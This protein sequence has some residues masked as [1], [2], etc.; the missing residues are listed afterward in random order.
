MSKRTTTPAPQYNPSAPRTSKREQ[1]RQERQRRNLTW[2]IIILGIAVVFLAAIGFAFYSGQR[3]GPLPGEQAVATENAAVFPDGQALT[4]NHYPP[5]SGARY[6]AAAPW[7][8]ATAPVDEGNYITNLYR[9]GVVFLYDCAQPCP[10]LEQQFRDLLA[11]ATPDSTYNTVKILVSP[12]P[13][14]K[15]LPAQ[16]VAL[17]WGHEL[18]QATFD[19]ATLLTWYKRFVNQGPG[20]AP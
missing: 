4:H 9:G 14:D 18:D 5:S 16:I 17:G 12:V 19:R 15:D 3:P 6:E 8:L 7:G 20:N 13:A 10:E 11:A 1:L 2:N